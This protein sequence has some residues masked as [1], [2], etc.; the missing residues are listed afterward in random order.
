MGVCRRRQAI[1]ILLPL[2]QLEASAHYEGD[3]GE[4]DRIEPALR[5]WLDVP[6]SLCKPSIRL[7]KALEHRYDQSDGLGSRLAALAAKDIG[8]SLEIAMQ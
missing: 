1:T 3:D 7:D 8:I 5:I 6:P 4:D 2:W